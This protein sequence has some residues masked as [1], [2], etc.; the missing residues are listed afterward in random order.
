MLRYVLMVVA[1]M[2]S[3]VMPGL[4]QAFDE[5]PDA[6]AKTFA[7]PPAG[8]DAPRDGIEHGKLETVEYDSTIVGG[9]RKAQV[10]T[11]PGYSAERKYP[12]LYLLH[13]IRRRRVRV[14]PRRQS[15]R[16]PR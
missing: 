15:Q 8:F 6:E 12:V 10:Y 9:K 2:A 3:S 4:A 5:K 1:A 7:A 11:P 13:G 16:D 14:D